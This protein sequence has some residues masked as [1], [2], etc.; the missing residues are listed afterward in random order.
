MLWYCA[1][2]WYHHTNRQQVAQRILQQHEA[3]A[4]SN[5]TIRGWYNLARGGSGFLLVDAQTPQEVTAMLQPYMDLMSWD[6]RAIYAL[7]YDQQ[8]QEMRQVAGTSV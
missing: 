1:F 7:D 6:V 3:G 2:T 4:H 5:R 8:I